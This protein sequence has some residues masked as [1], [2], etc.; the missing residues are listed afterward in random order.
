MSFES[1]SYLH[2]PSVP[3][4]NEVGLRYRVSSVDDI[5][6]LIGVLLVFWRQLTAMRVLGLRLR[7]RSPADACTL[8]SQGA[9]DVQPAALPSASCQLGN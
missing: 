8:L 2:G 1:I 9:L 5:S 6:V 7:R 3:Q 4:A